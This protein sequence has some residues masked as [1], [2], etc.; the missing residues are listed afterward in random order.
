MF[1]VAQGGKKLAQKKL[2]GQGNY[3]HASARDPAPPISK[4]SPCALRAFS[5]LVCS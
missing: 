1:T 2:R 5:V 3:Y 4:V